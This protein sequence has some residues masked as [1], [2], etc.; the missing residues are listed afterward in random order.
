VRRGEGG[1]VGGVHGVRESAAGPA[2]QYALPCVRTI[3]PEVEED[4]ES[5]SVVVRALP[6]QTLW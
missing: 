4:R 1:G 5:E 6:T 3:Y 2:H